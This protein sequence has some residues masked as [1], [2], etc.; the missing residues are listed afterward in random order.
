MRSKIYPS[1]WVLLPKAL[2]AIMVASILL[3]CNLKTAVPV[4]VTDIG[5]LVSVS[6]SNGGS[7]LHAAMLLETTMGYY[8]VRG[9]RMFARQEALALLAFDNGGRWVCNV[10]K[11]QCLELLVLLD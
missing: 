7:R 9:Q 3:G 11:D 2:A 8:P 10:T 6:S 5:T 4:S 1:G